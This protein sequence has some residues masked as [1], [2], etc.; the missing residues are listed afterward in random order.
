MIFTKADASTSDEQ[1]YNFI[2]EFNIHYR[3]CI[4]SFIYLFSTRVDL[5]FSVHKLENIHQTLVKYT[6][7]IGTYIEVHYGK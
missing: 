3:E 2:R 5:S 7:K 1:V 6:L 4:G